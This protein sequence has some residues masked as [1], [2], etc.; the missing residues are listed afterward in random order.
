MA[1]P[2]STPLVLL[3]DDSNF[4]RRTCR[5]MVEALGYRVVEAASGAA[6]LE[7]AQRED[8]DIVLLDLVM[9]GGMDGFQ[10]LAELRQVAPARQVV[11]V[12][13]DVQVGAK[14]TALAGGALGYLN[15]PVSSD[16][17]KKTLAQLV[18][19]SAP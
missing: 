16:E 2:S 6:A 7:V 19:Q 3:V 5:R 9:D 14:E 1:P 8:P 4:A 17:L 11:I 18:R 15:K 10:T 13:A 12:S